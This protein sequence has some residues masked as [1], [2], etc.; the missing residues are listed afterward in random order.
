[1]YTFFGTFVKCTS[2]TVPL[3]MQ[4]GGGANVDICDVNICA[5]VDIL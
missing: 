3:Q 2:H 5:N 1:M 4:I